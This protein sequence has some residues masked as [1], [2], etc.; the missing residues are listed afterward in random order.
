MSLLP[1]FHSN[2]LQDTL[3]KAHICHQNIHNINLSA[4]SMELEDKG[5]FRKPLKISIRNS[6]N[7]RSSVL[8]QTYG[9]VSC[10]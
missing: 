4:L 5:A 7:S 1:T 8:V 9:K 6:S 3:L 10:G 2:A